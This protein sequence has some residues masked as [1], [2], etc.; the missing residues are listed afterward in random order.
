MK[1]II[2]AGGIGTRLWPLSRKNSPKQFDKIFNGK[3]TLELAIER[4]SPVVGIENIFIQTTSEFAEAV[5]VQLPSL[6]DSNIFIEPMRR[7]VGP[8]VCYGMIKLGNTNER[9]PTPNRRAG[10]TPF[11]KGGT[12]EISSVS[13]PLC[14]C[15]PNWREGGQ[16]DVEN[17]EPV[18]LLWADHLMDNVD[19]F[20]QALLSAEKLIKSKPDRF[21]F[22][23]EKSRFA[24]NNL[25]WI[26]VG[27]E[28]GKINGKNY[29]KFLGWKYKPE[30]SECARMFKQGNYFWNP[31]YFIS[32]I[33]FILEQYKKLSPKIYENVKMA[34]DYPENAEEHYGRAE[35][36]SFD[37]AIIEKTDLS[38]AVVLKTD[39]K[40]SDPGTLYALKEA[41][42]KSKEA[43]VIKGNVIELNTRDSLIYNF[44][45]KKLITTVGLDGF[46]II[47]TKDALIVVPKEEVVNVTNLVEKI[48]A[49]G[50]D[51]YL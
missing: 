19:E 27:D 24:N 14:A 36:I 46:V 8:A 30:Q 28:I 20:Q 7:N 49:Q 21:V 41:L 29:F 1:I 16:G 9:I 50:L 23:G 38:N 15:P 3:S 26:K 48:E 13:A 17:D 35:K 43:N 37:K 5:K 34:I 39:M 32:S 11:N 45:N 4:V 25:G 33:S 6:P 51:E 42:Q 2:F 10:L 31:G 12:K 18:A 47:N 22:L 44:E 40:W